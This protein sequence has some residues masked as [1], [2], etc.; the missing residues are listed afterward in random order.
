MEGDIQTFNHRITH[1]TTQQIK[2]R[3]HN[4]GVLEKIQKKHSYIQQSLIQSKNQIKKE[5]S[6]FYMIPS[7]AF[8]WSGL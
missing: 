4:Q 5:Y 2:P 1:T 3:S 6:C 8:P 7:L